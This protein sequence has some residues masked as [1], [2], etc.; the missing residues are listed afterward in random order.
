MSM[1]KMTKKSSMQ[2]NLWKQDW[3]FLQMFSELKNV[4]L[5]TYIYLFWL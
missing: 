4:D 3:L 5:S 2:Y 1:R